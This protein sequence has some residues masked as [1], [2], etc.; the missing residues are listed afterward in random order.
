MDNKC[1]ISNSDCDGDSTENNHVDGNTV[2]D[3]ESDSEFNASM[4]D[5]WDSNN[6]IEE[7]QAPEVNTS[8]EQSR[9]SEAL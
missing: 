8:S 9:G 3:S 1:E 2:T 7:N 5:D 4:L 6:N